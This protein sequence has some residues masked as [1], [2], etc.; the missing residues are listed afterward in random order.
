M[1]RKAEA[2]HRRATMGRG[3]APRSNALELLAD[4][5]HSNGNAKHQTGVGKH[6][7]GIVQ[8]SK[9]HDVQSLV[10][11]RQRCEQIH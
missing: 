7:S 5:V 1:P 2:L 10:P 4:V 9:G 8:T 3:I 11:R 6:C